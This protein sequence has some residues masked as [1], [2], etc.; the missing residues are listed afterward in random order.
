MSRPRDFVLVHG[1]W[2]GA[3]C[4]GRVVP[5]LTVEGHRVFAPT[6]TGLADRRHLLRGDVDLSTHIA[7]VA[8]LIEW[9]S[10][11]DVVLVGHSYGGLVI[12]G[13]AERMEGAIESLVF[14]DALIPDDGQAA[15]DFAGGML[16]ARDELVPSGDLVPVVDPPPAAFFA[17]NEADQDWVDQRCTPHPFAALMERISLN[18]A[19]D[20]VARKAFMRAAAFPAPYQDEYLAIAEKAPDWRA[21][22]LDGGHDL[23]VD[24]PDELTAALLDFVE[25]RA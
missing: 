7:D 14:V 24:V 2:H 22:A 4:W 1:G 23:M 3:W 21:Y 12:S 11:S 18:G 25:E 6:L 8:N 20:R 19:R 5:R 9:E 13:V 10:L 17:V 16:S 15:L